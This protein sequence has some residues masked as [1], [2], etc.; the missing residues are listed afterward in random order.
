MPTVSPSEGDADDTLFE[1]GCEAGPVDVG[2]AV[3]AD[4]VSCDV[5]AMVALWLD[6]NMLPVAKLKPLT[7]IPKTV[8]CE[9]ITTVAVNASSSPCWLKYV[10]VW[11]LLTVDMH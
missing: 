3:D 5:S 7:G 9:G 1:A 4:A 2:G 8:A 6:D 11:P 10:N